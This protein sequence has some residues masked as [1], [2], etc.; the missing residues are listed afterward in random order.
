MREQPASLHLPP[1]SHTTQLKHC[2][3]N[4]NDNENKTQCVKVNIDSGVSNSRAGNANSGVAKADTELSD[5]AVEDSPRLSLP[6]RLVKQVCVP[7]GLVKQGVAVA[8]MSLGCVLDGTVLAYSSPALPSMFSSSS[9]IQIN[10]HHGSWIGSVHTL[11]AVLGCMLSI[12]AMARLGRRGAALYVMSLA[13]LL[14]YLLIGF[15]VN[16]EMIILGRVLGGVGLGLTLSITPVYLVEVS[17]I[18]SRGMLGAIPPIFTQV[19]LLATYLAGIWLDWKNLALSGVALIIPNVVFIWAIPES[20]VYLA[21]KGY[22]SAAEDALARLDR[23]EVS[24]SFFKQVQGETQ[25]YSSPDLFATSSSSSASSVSSSSLSA[26]SQSFTLARRFYTHPAVWRPTLVCFAIMFFFQATGYNT[27]IAYAKLI[28][29]RSG[30]LMDEHLACGLTGGVVLASS[31]IALIMSKLVARRRLLMTSSLGC[32]MNLIVMGCYYYLDDVIAQVSKSGR[33]G[34]WEGIRQLMQQVSWL[35]LACVLTFITAFMVGYGAV[36]W[37]VMAEVLPSAA[38]GR[39]YPFAVAFTW[40]CNFLFALGFGYVE[41]SYAFWTFGGLTLL[42]LGFVV[43]CV[44][45]TGGKSAEEI[46]SFFVTP[47]SD[48]EHHSPGNLATP[49]IATVERANPC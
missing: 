5:N 33:H 15:A 49:A 1:Y 20:P 40:V 29:L 42:G 8:G 14:G 6:V 16:V 18:E 21:S 48:D 10:L 9:S 39:I 34:D 41:E 4:N 28:L 11:G 24:T 12:P 36:A 43:V 45:E 30:L 23:D 47:S 27:I 3:N 17:S 2:N 22:F 25:H 31:V 7:R 37:T 13:Y 44:P 19:G 35:P 46:A 26:T 38:R 32:S